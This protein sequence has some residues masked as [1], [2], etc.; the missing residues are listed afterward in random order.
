[1]FGQR[2][3]KERESASGQG[4]GRSVRLTEDILSNPLLNISIIHYLCAKE[5]FISF[6]VLINLFENRKL[7]L[8]DLSVTPCIAVMKMEVPH[9]GRK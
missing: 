2:F 4:L 6:F 3:F 7:S 9:L 5:L 1:M 8:P